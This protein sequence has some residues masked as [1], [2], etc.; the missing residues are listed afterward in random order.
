[1]IMRVEYSDVP[2]E[3]LQVFGRRVCARALL[4]IVHT[5]SC[6]IDCVSDDV[7]VVRD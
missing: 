6:G 7:N 2:R 3:W 4:V 1:M 5:H